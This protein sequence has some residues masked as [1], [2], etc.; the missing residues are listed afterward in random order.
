M[1]YVEQLQA[2]L[3]EIG[4]THLSFTPGERAH[5]ATSE[6]IAKALLDGIESVERGE[7]EPLVFGDSKREIS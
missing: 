6:E 5:E 4:C 3:K 2:K 1:N 7:A